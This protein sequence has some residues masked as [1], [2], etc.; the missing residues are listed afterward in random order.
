MGMRAGREEKNCCMS[1]CRNVEGYEA[2]L[3]REKGGVVENI[4]IKIVGN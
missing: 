1:I 4:S 3:R 2:K